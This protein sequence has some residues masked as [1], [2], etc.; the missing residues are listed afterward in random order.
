MK[1]LF[2]LTL[3]VVCVKPK[4]NLQDIRDIL[5]QIRPEVIVMTK[6]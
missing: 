5:K 2:L 3:L 6:P 4:N 1:H